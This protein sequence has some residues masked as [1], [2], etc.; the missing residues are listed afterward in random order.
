MKKVFFV[1]ILT[2]LLS[3]LVFAHAGM[4]HVLGTVTALTDHSMS[5]KTESGSAVVVL[6]DSAT[7]FV[8][9]AAAV[10][11][12]DIHVGDRVVVHA[13]KRGTELHA[14]EVEIGV[15]RNTKSH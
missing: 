8:K 13:R 14:A 7:Q 15:N 12:K 6:F 4:E 1:V 5:L 2:V 11:S 3:S 9:D 10:T